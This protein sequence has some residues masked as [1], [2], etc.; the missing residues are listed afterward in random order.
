MIE[1]KITQD[2]HG[3]ISVSGPIDNVA[4]CYAMLGIAHDLILLNFQ[5]NQA[6]AN[7]HGPR[8]VPASSVDLPPFP[9]G[10]G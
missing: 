3:Q 1:L 6:A 7:G 10:R 2:D 8:I 9:G 5:K 4:Q